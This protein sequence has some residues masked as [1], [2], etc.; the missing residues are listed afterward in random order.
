MIFLVLASLC[1]LTY[2]ARVRYYKY[3][4]GGQL[5]YLE[6]SECIKKFPSSYDREN[7]QCPVTT[8]A[9]QVDRLEGLGYTFS[10]ENA[11]SG[12][13][14]PPVDTSTLT[15]LLRSHNNDA[16]A[17]LILTRR[18]NKDGKLQLM[19]RY[20]CANS[21]EYAGFETWSRYDVLLSRC[22]ICDIY[23]VLCLI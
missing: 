11:T 21:A 9:D 6:D 22:S 4:C 16:Q 13:F 19:N 7:W 2:S 23:V 1:L 5:Q 10:D 14:S 18:I 20:L 8:S 15:D 3:W 12:N 17:C